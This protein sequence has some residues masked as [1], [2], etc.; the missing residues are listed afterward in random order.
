MSE[1][2]METGNQAPTL[3]DQTE[4]DM[5]SVLSDINLDELAEDDLLPDRLITKGTLV[6]LKE[7][8][9]HS[10]FIYFEYFDQPFVI[11]SYQYGDIEDYNNLLGRLLKEEQDKVKAEIKKKD[12]NAKDA[13]LLRAADQV[14]LPVKIQNYHF[15]KMVVCI[16]G[17]LPERLLDGTIDAGLPQAILDLSH[18]G[19]GFA[20]ID[21]EVV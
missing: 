5:P 13:D 3:A 12:P 16:P 2:E 1:N 21:A 4:A 14:Q 11:R 19:S 7:Q 15:L 8:Y 17:D 18:K 9:P 10:R 6:K 20:Q